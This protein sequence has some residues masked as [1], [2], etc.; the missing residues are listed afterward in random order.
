MDEDL[1][2]LFGRLAEG[3]GFEV[4]GSQLIDARRLR[5]LPEPATPKEMRQR[6]TMKVT[7]Y[8]LSQLRAEC[9][10]TMTMDAFLQQ[11]LFLY[12]VAKNK[13]VLINFEG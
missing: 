2:S 7:R 8:T 11:L 10:P 1:K 12:R 13:G 4:Q 5:R 9:P 3:L 6:T